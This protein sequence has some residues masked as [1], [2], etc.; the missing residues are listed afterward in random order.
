MPFWR[1]GSPEATE[2]SDKAFGWQG[3]RVAA[4]RGGGGG[5]GQANACRAPHESGL[6][7]CNGED[8]HTV[9]MC[10]ALRSSCEQVQQQMK[11]PRAGNSTWKQGYPAAAVKAL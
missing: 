8:R 5:G 6:Y 1:A 7:L 3:M 2:P 10:K 4:A 11:G 9:G